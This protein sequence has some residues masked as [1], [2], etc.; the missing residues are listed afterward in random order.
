MEARR[1]ERI[2][3]TTDIWRFAE[4]ERGLFDSAPRIP[5]WHLAHESRQ[6][7]ADVVVQLSFRSQLQSRVIREHDA[8]TVREQAAIHLG[9]LMVRSVSSMIVLVSAGYEPE[10]LAPFRRAIE[11]TLR[12]RSVFDD[13]SGETARGLFERRPGSS[14]K[15]LAVRYGEPEMII[16]LLDTMTHAEMPGLNPL[17]E[18]GPGIE[19]PVIDPHPR[20]GLIH[21]AI[22]LL[23]AGQRACSFAEIAASV[24][25]VE[26]EMPQSLAEQF[27]HFNEHPLSGMT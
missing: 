21:P 16:R 17:V 7:L 24:F 1:P 5:T 4:L 9:S 23:G 2:R 25:D 27:T 18:T 19:G 3:P 8:Q 14:L 20:R 22:L 6:I 10:A 26:V 11:A 15:R 12:C 13:R